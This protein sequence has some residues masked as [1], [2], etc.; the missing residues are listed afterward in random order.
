[1][2]EVRCGSK[3]LFAGLTVLCLL[4]S[5]GAWYKQASDL[6]K[7][8]AFAGQQVD[9]QQYSELEKETR[10]YTAEAPA[11]LAAS[12]ILFIAGIVFSCGICACCCFKKEHEAREVGDGEGP[13]KVLLES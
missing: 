12:L 8:N 6:E 9:F 1:M 2:A 5:F 13:Y 11:L 7:I 3:N 4:G 10:D